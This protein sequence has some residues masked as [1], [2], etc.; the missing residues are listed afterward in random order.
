VYLLEHKA[1]VSR[2]TREL[3]A[4]AGDLAEKTSA[5]ARKDRPD[6][7][8]IRHQLEEQRRGF[9]EVLSRAS[10]EVRAREEFTSRIGVVK[11]RSREVDRLLQAHTEDRP[12]ANRLFQTGTRA[13][14]EMERDSAAPEADWTVLRRKVDE[15]DEAFDRAEALARQDISLA[16]QAR[17]ALAAA[18]RRHHEAKTY[19]RLGVS[20]DLGPARRKIEE[21]RACM[22]KQAYEDAA[23]LAE[24]AEHEAASAHDRAIAE[25]REK[26]RIVNQ[27][28][29]QQATQTILNAAILFRSLQG[30][31]GGPIRPG[32]GRRMPSRPVF[33]PR[34]WSAGRGTSS[35]SWGTGTSQ[36]S[37]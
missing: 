11:A 22:G 7:P 5:A 13:L 23:R 30:G 6:W 33:S 9:E 36:S 26:Q 3:M 4:A 15:A 21:A 28:R 37:W 34:P 19:Y 17:D 25:A 14:G 12:R 32:A 1:T 10:G 31:R 20:A 2:G 27:R 16:A 29:L 35:S 18:E 8:A 24:E